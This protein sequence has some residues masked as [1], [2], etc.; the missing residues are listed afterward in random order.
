VYLDGQPVDGQLFGRWSPG[1]LHAQ[2]A[3]YIGFESHQGQPWH[4]TLPFVGVIDELLIFS[5]ALT[6]SEIDVHA[7]R[8]D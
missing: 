1:V 2:D 5:R 7:S 4:Q 8:I 6:L 3:C